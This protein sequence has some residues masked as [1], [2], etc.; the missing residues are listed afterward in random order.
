MYKGYHDFEERQSITEASL[1]IRRHLD[2]QLVKI[3]PVEQQRRKIN[4]LLCK[5]TN[6]LDRQFESVARDFFL[7][8]MLYAQECFASGHV[9]NPSED[10][11]RFNID[12]RDEN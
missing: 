11:L 3:L 4:K 2:A 9:A 10:N 7:E 12:Q 6:V 8:G 1:A 5:L